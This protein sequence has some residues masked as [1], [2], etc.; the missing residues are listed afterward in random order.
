MHMKKLCK[1]RNVSGHWSY[2]IALCFLCVPNLVGAQ[3]NAGRKEDTPKMSLKQLNGTQNVLMG[4]QDPELSIQSISSVSGDKLLH[5]PTFMMESSLDGT[6][7]G[8]YIDMSQGYI[9]SQRGFRLRGKTPLILVDGIPRAD[10]NI[11]A[12]QIESVSVIND[13]LG[14]SMMGMSSGNGV[15]Y[16]KT[17]R[18]QRTAMK[19][20][21]TA[22]L[23]YNQQ[24]FR[25]DFLNA[26][27][28]GSLLN[29]ALVND[30]KTPMYSQT[31]LD[32]YRTGG[33]PYTHPDVDWQ[34]QLLRTT[35]PTQQYNLNVSGGGRSARYFIDLNVY[36][37]DGFLKQDNSINS[38][39][40][41]ENAK[42][43]SLR[44]NT[45]ISITD[46]TQ[47]RVN[48]FGQMYRETT[49]GKAIMGSI[50]RDMYTT[51]NN[52]YPVFNPNG[53]LG[54]SPIHANNNLYGQSVLSGYYLYP[55]TDFSI[56]ATLEHHFQDMFKGLYASATY[57]YNSSYRE[58]LNRSKGFAVYSYWKDP[59][60]PNA[61][62]IYQQMA[63]SSGQ[64][65]G[66]S[67]D[68]LNRLQ[69]IELALGY[70][71]NIKKHEI[72][73]KALYS[74]ND[75]IVSAKN[76][77]LTKNALSFRAEYNYDRRY[78]AQFGL[79]Y[80][81]LNQLKPGEQW[82][83]F[84]SVG[85]GW[86]IHK[87]AWFESSTVNSLKLRSTFGINGSD[88][89]GS[90]YRNGTGTLSDYY[91]TYMK[92]YKTNNN[93]IYLG[94]TP[95]GLSTLTESNLPYLTKWEK[96]TRWN[97]GLDTELF[98]RSLTASVEYFH[99]IYDDILQGSISKEAN[100]LIG[101]TLP[102]ENLGKYR[103][104]GIEL[105]MAYN[106]QLGDVQLY[107]NANATFYQ[108]EM[109]VNGENLYP[110]SYM[111][112]VGQKYGQVFGYVSDGFFQ[113]Q[114]EINQYL[115]TTE[116]AG[117]V[118]QPGDLKYRDL[119]NDHILDGKDI[120][121]IGTDAPL[122]EY[123]FYLGASWKG[124]AL[125]MQWAGLGNSETTNKIMPFTFNSQGGY[126]QALEEHLD[127]W[128]PE[129][130]QARYPRLSA[131]SNSYNERTSTFWLQDA[132]YL[133]LK[134][135]ELSY[136]LPKSWTMHARISGVKLFTNA[137]NILTISSIKDRDP[138]LLGF[139]NGTST[140]LVPNT[141]A[142]NFGINIQF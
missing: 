4:T 106:K 49:P 61:Q 24:L 27:Q 86:N 20:D 10:V 135:I 19:I 100:S 32:L 69:Y 21:F 40:T 62:E 120:K 65:N 72:N 92:Y 59:T 28:Y 57:S 11:P 68:R 133:R 36:Q 66:T 45:D 90:Y 34:N 81:N 113:N 121:A 51:P 99:N 56:D 107:A 33:S 30:G 110:E 142:Y 115:A 125:S 134:N 84:P 38:Y 18:G 55:K 37:Q 94:T 22:Q 97:I 77:P 73:T 5:R 116:I 105:S 109:L 13:G 42:K 9:T 101:M 127:R 63:S 60:D 44:T 87:E 29:E 41:R 132:S 122:I 112:R 108:T 140:G 3:E 67:Y 75:Y 14:L 76:I 15:V 70:D 31:D 96:T 83:A 85:A 58:N 26:Y 12:S 93:G 138:E 79:S 123:G 17:K 119:N 23:A 48:L 64:S 82:G 78:M 130:Q 7:P 131:G 46:H 128:T 39:N 117:Y 74:Y 139:T 89:T 71:F 126:G 16:I 91:F 35:A 47:F 88:G 6:L 80:M 118:P 54:G 50:Y 1:L 103:R 114:Q 52:A 102:S 25:P 141:K 8:L 124:L 129:N 111:Q 2:F 53:T 136:T 98:D 43:Y 95:G 137:Y 104:S